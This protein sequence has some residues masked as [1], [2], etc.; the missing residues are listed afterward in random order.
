MIN[1]ENNSTVVNKYT[2]VVGWGGDMLICSY[3]Q[4]F[5]FFIE[6]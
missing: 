4:L 5:I 6:V 3:F 1:V 2:K